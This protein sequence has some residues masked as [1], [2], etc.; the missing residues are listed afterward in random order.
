MDSIDFM[1]LLPIL[2]LAGFSILTMLQVAFL[3]RS[4]TA[5]MMCGAGCVATLGSLFAASAV[6]PR[7]VT[8]LLTVDHYGLLYTGL[9]V[10]ATAIVTAFSYE[11]IGKQHGEQEEEYF[12]LLLL[13]ALGA[14][15]LTAANH[16][17]S[18]FLGLEL[19]GVSLYALIG[20]FRTRSQPIEAA[21]KYLIL[22]AASSAFLLFGMA[23][24]YFS[25]GTMAFARLGSVS[26]TAATADGMFV[27]GMAMT[28]MA[29]G[30]KLA[31]VPFHMWAP[32]VY[33]GAPAPVTAFVAT[34]S[35]GA[36]FALLV[37]YVTQLNGDHYPTIWLVLSLVAAASMFTG[38]LLALLQSN[39]KRMLAYSSIAHLGYLLVA[40]L[41][42]GPLAVEAVTFYLVAYF[43]TTLGAFGVVSLLTEP[44]R[45]TGARDADRMED[46]RGLFW[47]RPWLS[48]S[49]MLMLLSLAGIPLTIGFLGKFYVITAGVR[50][51]LWLLVIM[52]VINSV[53]GLFYYLRIIAA[54]MATASTHVS[55]A[56]R[57]DVGHPKW[58]AVVSLAVLT[59]LLIGLGLYPDTLIRLIQTMTLS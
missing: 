10:T 44:Q 28:L 14:V 46:Y 16:F 36:I 53:I 41:A 23:L 42:T 27:V 38:N 20:Y 9:I 5:A 47:S 21:I 33:E 7:A 48:A 54:M 34:I 31:V 51:S 39:V 40:F 32:D 25:T 50:S 15:V 24:M 1:A 17:A 59:L 8:S 13:A 3:R 22:S 58:A 37:R 19:M 30:F 56:P 18:F 52:L 57:Q 35:K 6:A 12:V 26:I 55:H 4:D 45:G 11:Y 2:T 43:V 29:L 49:F